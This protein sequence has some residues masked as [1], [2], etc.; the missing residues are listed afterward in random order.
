MRSILILSTYLCLGLSSTLLPSGVPTNNLHSFRFSLIHAICPAHLILLDLIILIICG[1]EYRSRRCPFWSFL[2]PPVT[3]SLFGPNILINTLF[4]NTFCLCSSL[5]VRDHVSQPKCS[6]VYSNFYAFRERMRRQK[7]L[8]W[9]VAS[10]SRTLNFP[11]VIDR[12]MAFIE[13]RSSQFI[14]NTT[15]RKRT[16]K[17][18]YIFDLGNYGAIM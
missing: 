15:W 16:E 8:D 1:E 11:F 4:S 6:L 9:M 2:H 3:S 10:I 5:N 14:S 17:A 7:V 18:Q 12:S 13:V